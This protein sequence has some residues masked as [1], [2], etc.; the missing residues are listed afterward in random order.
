MRGTKRTSSRACQETPSSVR[1]ASASRW[2][3][4]A[5]GRDHP[6]AGGELALEPAQH[7]AAGG[8]GD[9]DGVERGLVREPVRAVPDDERHVVDA[10][11]GERDGGLGA[12]GVVAL[13]RPHV[14]GQAGEHGRVIARAGA[15]VEHAVVR[16]QLEQLAHP[17]DDERLGDRLPAADAQRDVVVGVRPQ[18]RGHEGLARHLRDRPQDALVGDV[19]A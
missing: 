10:R 4:A 8:G 6:T 17:R 2:R 15:H 19:R 7:A 9:V 1:R 5:T 18:A 13:D 14:P 3:R 12:E 11:R 16:A